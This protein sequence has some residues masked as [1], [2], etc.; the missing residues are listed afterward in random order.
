MDAADRDAIAEAV[1]RAESRTA[2]EI[3]VVI[4]RAAASYRNVPVLMALTLALFVP[5]PLLSF[6]AISAQRIFMIQLFCAVLLL[7]G[8]LWHGRGGRF[9]PGFV[10]RRRA[11]EA[12]LR[13]F[14]ARGLTR[15]TGRT[16]VLLYIAL[17]ERYA[18]VLADTGI[19]GLVTQDTWSGII[20]P[21]LAAAREERLTEGL[22]KAVDSVGA[23]LAQHAPPVPGDIDELSNN[24]ILL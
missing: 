16:G 14:T 9:V 7:A 3:V 21:L 19:D 23:V 18:E 12:A 20:E 22:I 4:E 13:E 2:G 11:H 24:V 10:K 1:R 8:L 6:T 17:Q 5:W 15:T